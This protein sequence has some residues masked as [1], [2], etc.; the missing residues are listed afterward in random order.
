[1]DSNV[2]KVGEIT[3]EEQIARSFVP[4][5]RD[6]YKSR[7]LGLI[8]SGFAP[9]EAMKFL[10]IGKSAI[11]NWRTDPKYVEAEAHMPEYRKALSREYAGLEYMRN[12]R[13]VMEKDKQILDKSLHPDLSEEGKPLP[14]ANQDHSYLLKIRQT[15]TV[16]Q[17]Q[18]LEALVGGSVE[19][20]NFTDALKEAGFIQMERKDTITMVKPNG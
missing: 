2:T 13:M 1:M 18:L 7:Y 8:C 11:S 3:E 16:Q 9:R 5:P 6:D 12:F 19:G 17:L 15:Y 10:G 14:M 4:W 20:F